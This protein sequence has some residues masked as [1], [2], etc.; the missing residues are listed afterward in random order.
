MYL[1]APTN[2]EFRIILAAAAVMNARSDAR[3]RAEEGNL[4]SSFGDA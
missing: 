4:L 1:L 3:A 2:D